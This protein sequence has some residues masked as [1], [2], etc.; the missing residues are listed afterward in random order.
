MRNYRLFFFLLT[1]FYS[2]AGAQELPKVTLPSP[3]TQ[4]FMKY[5]DYPVGS[6]TGVP[7]I[8]IPLYTIKEGDLSVPIV[9]RYHA[10][11]A[12][13][14]DPNGFTGMGWSLSAGGKISCTIM[15]RSDFRTPYPANFYSASDLLSQSFNNRADNI[16][17]WARDYNTEPDIFT[18]QFNGNSGKFVLKNDVN[19]TPLLLPYKALKIV[20]NLASEVF[21]V[22]DAAG[23]KYKFSP[24][25]TPD[26]G[27]TSWSMS[28]MTSANN[29]GNTIYFQESGGLDELARSYGEHVVFDDIDDESLIWR[30]CY[31]D[32]GTE[33]NGVK[34]YSDVL[35]YYDAYYAGDYG[36]NRSDGIPQLITFLSGKVKFT[37]ATTNYMLQKIEIM[38]LSN[39]VKQSMEFVYVSKPTQRVLLKE[40]NF[41]DANHT[42]LNH[43][44]FDYLYEDNGIPLSDIAGTD[45]WGYYNS[46]PSQGLGKQLPNVS[47]PRL[48]RPALVLNSTNNRESVETLMKTFVLNKVTYPTGGFTIY[49]YECNKINPSAV[50][51]GRDVGG[52]RVKTISKYAS[53][54]STPETRTYEYPGWN[55]DFLPG[56]VE[57]YSYSVAGLVPDLAP[58]GS[59]TTPWSQF[60]RRY[61]FSDP[62]FNISPHGSP[63]VY[64]QVSEYIGNGQQNVG[65]I[66]YNYDFT[67]AEKTTYPSNGYIDFYSFNDPI[68]YKQY[69][70]P[71]KDWTSGN[72]IGKAYYKN[73]NGNY[74][75]VNAEDY[76]YQDLPGESVRG[77]KYDR[78][79]E[80]NLDGC[81]IR[82]NFRIPEDADYYLVQ[83]GGEPYNYGDYYIE[84]GYRRLI[85]KTVTS[86]DGV[87]EKTK[88][89]YANNLLDAPTNSK[90][91]KSNGDSVISVFKYPHDFIGQQ[92][93]ADM[94]NLYHKWSPVIEQVNYKNDILGTNI[95][96]TTRTNYSDWGNSIIAPSTVEGRNMATGTDETRLRYHNYDTKG[97]PLTISKENGSKISYLYSYNSQFPIAEIKNADYATVESLLGGSSAVSSFSNQASPDKTAIDN[98]LLPL[99]NNLPDAFI[100]SYV[101]KPLIGMVS[102]TDAKGM[103]VYYEY[104]AFQRLKLVRDQNNNI[105]KTYCYNYAGQVTD[106]NAG[107]GTTTPPAPSPV[108]ARVEVENSVSSPTSDGSST[109]ADFYIALYSDAN[110]TQ[111]VSL[112]QSID[113]NVGTSSSAYENNNYSTLSWTN[114]Y[115][116]PSN[117]NR[118]YLGRF[119]TDWWYW[120]YDPYY[121]QIINSYY[122]YYQI[123]DN[124]MNTYIPAATY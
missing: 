100:S 54:T 115:T 30:D 34:P 110:C 61:L 114:T 5:V 72:L 23:V 102:Q 83:Y 14:S 69:L 43:Y 82:P 65:K 68:R 33:F 17:S 42:F 39:T 55:I 81:A 18:Y 20:P 58:F 26:N 104:D 117:T 91:Y 52:L 47:I 28:Q 9:L 37:F 122:Y 121:E 86:G 80:Y 38:D 7:D 63:V 48:H 60:R 113:V 64:D 24:S 57:D 88:F 124:G 109:D 21:D 71:F 87:I 16:S 8:E 106:C 12:K 105:V 49:D 97:N 50:S 27:Y 15:G 116:V 76:E 94:V 66:S 1:F 53:P 108:Y 103:T 22:W 19:K 96:S 101:Y 44:L 36:T 89:E 46:S 56:N 78:Y 123:E 73:N 31:P 119:T 92:P 85:S 90:M 29:P 2:V 6:F 107:G 4:Q 120:Y 10:S 51:P 79:V 32:V 111:S 40:I 93:Y 25:G 74:D 77:F 13:P 84:S 118:L 62:L 11:G 95:L 45:H 41:Y 59:S 99:R 75:L 98:F 70:K 67:P 3:S 112:P 35:S